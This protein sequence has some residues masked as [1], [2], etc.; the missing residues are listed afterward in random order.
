MCRGQCIQFFSITPPQKSLHVGRKLLM[1]SSTQSCKLLFAFWSGMAQTQ[2]ELDHWLSG[3][4]VTSLNL[5]YM[6]KKIN[7]SKFTKGK[8][9]LARRIK[10]ANGE[11]KNSH[12]AMHLREDPEVVMDDEVNM[13]WQCEAVAK[14]TN[15][16]LS[17]PRSCLM[18]KTNGIIIP[19]ILMQV[20]LYWETYIQFWTEQLKEKDNSRQWNVK[21]E[22]GGG[23][24][25]TEN[26]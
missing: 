12:S 9:N 25:N 21:Q 3:L 11:R 24:C 26:W 8:H 23:K 2:Q 22:R 16:L 5:R 14:L 15:V 1:W 20:W 4:S 10:S 6:P 17:H 13:N 18:C 7:E 19:L